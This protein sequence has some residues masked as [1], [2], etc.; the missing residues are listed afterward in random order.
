MRTTV[1]IPDELFRRAKQLALSRETTLKELVICA[2][3]R[4]I[5]VG[6]TTNALRRVEFPLVRSGAAGS[7]SIS[8]KDIEAIEVDDD[9]GR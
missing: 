9:V 7:V 5:E 6:G 4:E 3:R 2:L 1:E 8:T